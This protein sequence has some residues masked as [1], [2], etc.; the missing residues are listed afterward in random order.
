M[1]DHQS[2]ETNDCIDLGFGGQFLQSM[3]S[4]R[5]INSIK[6][7]NYQADRSQIQHDKYAEEQ[8]IE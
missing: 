6:L 5:S 1:F 7:D 8:L 4:I 3:H 2:K